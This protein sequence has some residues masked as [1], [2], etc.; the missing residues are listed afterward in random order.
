MPLA[1]RRHP[2]DLEVDRR[3]GLA[4]RVGERRAVG[5]PVRLAVRRGVRR[6]PAD[7]AAVRVHAEDVELLGLR[8]GPHA[9]ERDPPVER[10]GRGG[11]HER[12]PERRADRQRSPARPPAAGTH[13]RARHAFNDIRAAKAARRRGVIGEGRSRGGRLR[14]DAPQTWP[15]H[16]K[17]SPRTSA[18]SCGAPSERLRTASK[19][20]ESLV[21]TDPIKNRWT[22][23]PA[24][25]EILDAARTELATAWRELTRSYSEL[26]GWDPPAG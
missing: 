20:L 1:R 18:V 14:H 22:P 23:E 21:A 5:R 16:P 17:I 6:Q 24:P 8:V 19:E 12:Q 2:R 25:P 13:L 26:L 9:G 10:V 11:R 15:A 3:V 7:V 4:D